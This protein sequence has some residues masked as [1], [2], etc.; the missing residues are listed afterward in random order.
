M[1]RQFFKI[2][3]GATYEI[4]TAEDGAITL[5]SQRRRAEVWGGIA[6]AEYRGGQNAVVQTGRFRNQPKGTGWGARGRLT[7]DTGEGVETYPGVL[8]TT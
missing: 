3:G 8:V 7:I 5:V 2:D 1:T 6:S 4:L